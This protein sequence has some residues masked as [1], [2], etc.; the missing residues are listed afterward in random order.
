MTEIL[1]IILGG[2]KGTRLYPLTKMR[3]K[4]AVPFGGKYRLVDIP[5][6]NCI[7]SGLKQ[8][9]ILTQFNSSSL[10]NH[11]SHT[12][13]FDSFS[14]GFV[15]ILAAEQTYESSSWFQG[16]ADAVRKNIGHFHDH[17]PDYYLIL[18]GDQLFRMDI[19]KF[20]KRHIELKADITIASTP[21]SREDASALGILA[22]DQNGRINAFL[23]KPS[24]EV[25]IKEMRIPEEL[26]KGS[27]WKNSQ[28]DYLASMGIYIFN[29]RT[30]EAAL[31]N[32]FTDFGKEIIPNC[33]DRMKLCTYVFDG[34]WED[35]GSI[36]SFYDANIDLAAITP[37]F[38]F[39]YEKQPIYTRRRDLPASKVNFC[40]TSQ[41]LTADGCIITNA[42]IMNSIVGIR[43]II[44]TGAH[45]DA[46]V[47]MGLIIMKPQT[48]R[49]KIKPWEFRILELDGGQLLKM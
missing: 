10:H 39:Y 1:S 12:Y 7:N 17:S 47:C 24:P 35:I 43:T 45:L 6:S 3:A 8:I 14:R 37:N 16:T 31:D 49:R 20:I 11:I 34:Y 28:R 33:M 9:Y 23:E 48:R 13:I 40:T 30:L 42:T 22:A 38:N 21:V 32:N 36:K 44:E 25:D 5:I 2:G 4:P 19:R 29:A 41:S 15:E 27:K 46:A 18:S 26:K